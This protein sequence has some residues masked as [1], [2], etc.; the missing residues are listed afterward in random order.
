MRHSP[1]RHLPQSKTSGL[2][3][4]Q[5]PLRCACGYRFRHR[6]QFH[7]LLNGGECYHETK[8]GG[9]VTFALGCPLRTVTITRRPILPAEGCSHVVLMEVFKRY[10]KNGYTNSWRYYT[11]LKL[12]VLLCR[13]VSFGGYSCS[14]WSLT[15]RHSFLFLRNMTS[16]CR[17][18]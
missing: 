6:V 16:S 1:K 2:P 4:Q 10:V 18:L 7:G 8:G 14:D 3:V 9:V 11:D 17:L 13:S 12:E 5:D 15:I